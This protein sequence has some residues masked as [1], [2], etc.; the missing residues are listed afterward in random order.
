VAYCEQPSAFGD[1]PVEGINIQLA[2]VRD[3]DRAKP[4][5]GLL[6]DQLPGQQVG[7]MLQDSYQHLV[8]GP[9]RAPPPA[10]GHQIDGL[11]RA[12]GEHDLRRARGAKK[13]RD[14]L[15]CVVV[16]RGGPLA[17]VVQSTV[18]VGVLA[19][20]EARD[21]VDHRSGLLTGGRIVEIDQ[22]TS[23]PHG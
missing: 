22:P 15:A 4:S 13:T 12:P 19:G 16:G 1:Q 7:V 10:L 3:R 18:D 8:A 23:I 14:L 6:A 9:E 17:E 11:G 21:R 2:L 20:I 5:A